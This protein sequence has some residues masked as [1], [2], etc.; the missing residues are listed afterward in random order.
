MQISGF[1]PMPSPYVVPG[2]P[3]KKELTDA[4]K[5]EAINMVVAAVYRIDAEM[6]KQKNRK[7]PI[8]E[9]RQV[10]MWWLRK[11]TNMTHSVIARVYNI[12]HATVVHAFK[13]V[14]NLRQFNR[15]FHANLDNVLSIIKANPMFK[16]GDHTSKKTAVHE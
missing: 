3:R 16:H 9:A 14:E 2:I 4:E 7:Q 12:D 13:Q 5:I 8:V 15:S 10:A 11:N 1:K 6:L